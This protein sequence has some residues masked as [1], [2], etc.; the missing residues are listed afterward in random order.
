MNM[1]ASRRDIGEHHGGDDM[2]NVLKFCVVTPY[3]D[4]AYILNIPPSGAPALMTDWTGVNNKTIIENYTF[5]G[6]VFR[7]TFSVNTPM[8]A[9]IEILLNID[10]TTKMIKGHLNIGA[11]LH[12]VTEGTST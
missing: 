12:L 6:A 11:Y 9:E 8:D 1:V 2:S 5:D 4:E 3:G 10:S 7:A